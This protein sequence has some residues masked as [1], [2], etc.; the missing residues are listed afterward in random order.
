MISNLDKHVYLCWIGL[1][2]SLII[3]D[4]CTEWR[5]YSPY[6][7]PLEWSDT[8]Q[9]NEPSS[10][11][12]IS[13]ACKGAVSP[14]MYACHYGGAFRGHSQQITREGAIEP[15]DQIGITKEH[16]PWLHIPVEYA[17]SV[18][19]RCRNRNMI[20]N[21]LADIKRTRTT[22]TLKITPPPPPH[23]YPYY[24]V[25]LDPKSKEDK[26]KVTNFK[27]LPKLLK[28]LDKMYKYEMDPKSI[29]EDTE[30]TRFCPQTD[31]QT[32]WNQYTP[33]STSLKQGV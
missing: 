27:N 33:L 5:K 1:S 7:R 10:H 32:R 15:V 19:N 6:S 11:E 21:K 25:I 28:L 8:K 24:W 20:C 4:R 3:D 23:D 30:R 14:I 12:L 31:R 29:V 26:V 13:T 2:S 9:G 22:R 17:C 18:F 16:V